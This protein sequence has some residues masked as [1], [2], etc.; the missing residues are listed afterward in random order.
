MY[1][2]KVKIT[3]P[4]LEN[5]FD[6]P[7]QAIQFKKIADV[8]LWVGKAGKKNSVAKTKRLY[9]GYAPG[10]LF[11]LFAF[12]GWLFPARLGWPGVGPRRESLSRLKQSGQSFLLFLIAGEN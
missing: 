6:S 8:N 5:I 3:F 12:D 10:F 7:T 2:V 11:W 9:W 1:F 4:C